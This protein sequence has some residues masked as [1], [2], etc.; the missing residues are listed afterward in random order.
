MKASACHHIFHANH[1]HCLWKI[2]PI[3]AVKSNVTIFIQ[4]LRFLVNMLYCGRFAFTVFKHAEIK[5]V[6]QRLTS[7][8]SLDH[9]YCEATR[10]PSKCMYSL[11][12]RFMGPTWGPSGADRTQVSPMLA[13]WILLS[14]LFLSGNQLGICIS[15]WVFVFDTTHHKCSTTIQNKPYNNIYKHIIISKIDITMPNFAFA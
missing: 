10:S 12:A 8:A 15:T 7:T 1:W 9:G 2:R 3:I 13:L 14:G 4:V 6:R 11:I 5:S